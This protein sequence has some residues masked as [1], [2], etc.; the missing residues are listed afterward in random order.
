MLLTCYLLFLFL[1]ITKGELLWSTNNRKYTKKPAS[2]WGDEGR[3]RFNSLVEQEKVNRNNY[4]QI[5]ENDSSDEEEDEREDWLNYI[6]SN[7]E[8]I[9]ENVNENS[10]QNQ[11]RWATPIE[12]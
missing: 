4:N 3:K 11:I 2:S 5:V 12:V 1:Q 7:V 10:P 6:P 8:S 9:S